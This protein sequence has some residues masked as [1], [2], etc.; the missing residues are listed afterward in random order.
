MVRKLCY[1]MVIALVIV[2]ALDTPA[3]AQ[4]VTDPPNQPDRIRGQIITVEASL[5]VVKTRDGK[6]VRLGVPDNL[7][8]LSLTKASFT[9]V[10][11]GTYVGAVSKGR[12]TSWT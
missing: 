4:T 6:T 5:I 2:P 11:F 3:L 8:V 1:L 7:S 12:H 10:E 9:E